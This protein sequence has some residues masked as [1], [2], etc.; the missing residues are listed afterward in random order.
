MLL[1]LAAIAIAALVGSALV[2]SAS[3]ELTCGNWTQLVQARY[4]CLDMSDDYL[5][6]YRGDTAANSA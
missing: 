6:Y 4:Q 3:S 5:V 2:G 1:S